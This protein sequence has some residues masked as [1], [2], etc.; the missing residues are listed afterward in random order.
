MIGKIKVETPKNLFKIEFICL[1]SK[2]F[3]FRCGIPNKYKLKSISK[4]QSR[5]IEFEDYCNCLFGGEY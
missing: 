5:N 4:T 3:S 1:R 2:A